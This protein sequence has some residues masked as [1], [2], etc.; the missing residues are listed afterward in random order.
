LSARGARVGVTVEQLFAPV[1]GGIGRYVAELARR[2]PALAGGAGGAVRFISGRHPATALA[3][4]PLDR[5]RTTALAL[6]GRV[7]AR[8]W[9][10]W[11]R[12]ALPRRLLAALD[13]V[14]A[15]S[16]AVPPT[17]A[18]PL[19]VTVHDLA[20]LHHPEA[21][22]ASGRRWHEL[23]TR[24]ATSEAALLLTPSAATAADLT[25]RYGVEP[26][27]TVVTP[28]GADLV[29]PDLAGARGLLA[30]LGVAG[31]Y[32]LTV[33][34]LEP[35]KNLARLLDAFTQAGTELGDHQLVVVGPTGWGPQPPRGATGRAQ[36]AG[37]VSDRVLHGLY[38]LADGL[39]YPSLYEGFGL[40]VVEAMAHGIPV[41]TSDR[42]S[43]PEVAGDAALLVDP[44]DTAAIAAGLVRL[45]GDADLR[46]RLEVA[47]PRRAARFTW[48][49]TAEATWNAYV[50]AL[51]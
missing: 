16:A 25:E 11:R 24:V 51:A 31:P 42:S 50:K 4:T 27:R 9:V 3:G 45:A 26:D 43:L 10:A 21:Y 49:A 33:G 20:F 19:A 8:T 44:T 48:D 13:L 30:S 47:G 32:L 7:A 2:L 40:P 5:E 18:V 34:T 29:E 12:P 15:T 37:K 38:A 41:L 23:A 22:P 35:R 39:A 1:P 14:H 46:G 28:L 17:R 36:L 6:P